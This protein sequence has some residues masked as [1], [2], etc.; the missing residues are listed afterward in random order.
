MIQTLDL[1]V[2]SLD[3]PNIQKLNTINADDLSCMWTGN[4]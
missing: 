4:F 1:P 2:L 3:I